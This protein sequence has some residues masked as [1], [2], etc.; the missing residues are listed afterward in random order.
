MPASLPSLPKFT[1]VWI[2]FHF[3]I[4]LFVFLENSI[5]RPLGMEERFIQDSQVHFS[6]SFGGQYAQ[7]WLSPEA[8]YNGQSW[9]PLHGEVRP[10]LQIDFLRLTKVT[11]LKTQGR[12]SSAHLQWVVTYYLA[13]GHDGDVFLVYRRNG[14]TKVTKIRVRNVVK[15]KS[16][17]L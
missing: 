11:K 4:W 5:A 3:S 8:G 6:T 13:F 14:K 1:V 17:L 2:K 9:I 10:W 15:V 12:P 16:F 7:P